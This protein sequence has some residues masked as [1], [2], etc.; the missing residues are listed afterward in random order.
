MGE[1][2]TLARFVADTR[3]TDLPGGLVDNCKIAVLDAL[4]AGFVGSVQ[5]WTTRTRRA[6]RTT[7]SAASTACRSPRR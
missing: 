6:P 4:G 1:T 7:S 2:R 3:F 5:P